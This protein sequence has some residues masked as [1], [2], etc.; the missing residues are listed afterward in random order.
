MVVVAV[1]LER[2]AKAGADGREALHG[3][4]K[5]DDEGEQKAFEAVRHVLKLYYRPHGNCGTES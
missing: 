1:V 4:G 5:C 3:H 2:H